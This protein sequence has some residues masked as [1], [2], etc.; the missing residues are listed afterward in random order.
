M[1]LTADE[2]E[3]IKFV[4]KLREKKTHERTENT[5]SLRTKDGVEWTKE[6]QG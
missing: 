4:S 3:L 1:T 2:N 6:K 5:S